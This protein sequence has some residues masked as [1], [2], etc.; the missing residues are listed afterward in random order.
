[1]YCMYEH[2]KA[3][4]DVVVSAQYGVVEGMCGCSDGAAA[5]I[6]MS[7]ICMHLD[8]NLITSKAELLYT[9]LSIDIVVSL[10]LLPAC[11]SI[12]ATGTARSAAISEQ[13]QL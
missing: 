9:S 6:V 13:P 8:V 4:F 10:T 1:M 11:L 2:V 5:A 12:L 3:E 7:L